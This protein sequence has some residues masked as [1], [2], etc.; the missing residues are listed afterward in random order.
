[1]VVAALLG[2]GG[3]KERGD[4]SKNLEGKVSLVWNGE[5]LRILS[6]HEDR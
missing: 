4:A 3:R 5:P 6:D 2:G 1:V